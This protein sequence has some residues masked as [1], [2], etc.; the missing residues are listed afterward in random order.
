MMH[1][2]LLLINPLIGQRANRKRDLLRV[3]D[4]FRNA[5]VH[6][7]TRETPDEHGAGALVQAIG[8]EFDAVIVCGG[9]GTIFDAVQGAVG[10]SIP[11]GIVPFG[12]GNILA[13]NLGIPLDAVKAVQALLR[14]RQR[15]V[16]LGRI[17]CG[18][19]G[20]EPRSWYFLF[21]AGLGMHAS[22]LGASTAWGK[23]TIGPAA[24]YVAGIDLL[25]RGRIAPFEMETTDEHGRVEVRACCEAIGVRVGALN[26]WR[27]G[28]GLDRGSIRIFAVPGASRAAL[29]RASFH[30]MV[31]RSTESA[32]SP[33]GMRGNAAVISGDFVRAVFRPLPG[34]RYAS[35]IEVQADGEVLGT[36]S[37][38]L[39]ITDQRVALLTPE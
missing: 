11:I 20:E 3:Q 22:L 9:D 23:H 12:T 36:S 14:S 35:P 38:T 10:T 2:V 31:L 39:E 15:C 30:A 8:A 16:P 29:A 6:V 21:A 4:A 7:V 26:R 25:L 37:A 19:E 28:G 24:Y 27:P 18:F 33:A 13:Q 1:R 5:G 34:Y 17:T 32:G